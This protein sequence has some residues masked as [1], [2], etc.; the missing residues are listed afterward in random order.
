MK[1]F[2]D[3]GGNNFKQY[4]SKTCTCTNIDDEIAAL[5]AEFEDLKT[6]VQTRQGGGLYADVAFSTEV[7]DDYIRYII[8]YGVP[9]DGIFD[10][11]KLQYVS[12]L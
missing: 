9:E 8:L 12:T 7:K 3:C 4:F 5:R 11:E 6:Y 10:P 2:F 1:S